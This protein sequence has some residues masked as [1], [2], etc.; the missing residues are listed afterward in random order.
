MVR[1]MKKVVF[2]GDIRL[3]QRLISKFFRVKRDFRVK[4]AEDSSS[5]F[6]VSDFGSGET[7]EISIKVKTNKLAGEIEEYV[8]AYLAGRLDTFSEVSAEFAGRYKD[9]R[10][11]EH[12]CVVSDV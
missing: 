5:Y 8:R 1:V 9:T 12:S 4:G 3:Y 11:S 10:S 6:S 2:L 7:V